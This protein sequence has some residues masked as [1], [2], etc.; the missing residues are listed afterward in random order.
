MKLRLSPDRLND[1]GR[2]QTLNADAY[3]LYLRGRDQ[4]H[5]R[6]AD[7]NARAI[8]LYKRAIA[9]DGNYALA[10]ADLAFT[11]AAATINGDAPPGAVGPRAREAAMQSVRAN[12]ELPEAQLSLG[13]S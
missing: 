1:L 10:W 5:R 12:P 3:D 13:T 11:Y 7:G 6:T 2:R 4:A 9:I 8:E